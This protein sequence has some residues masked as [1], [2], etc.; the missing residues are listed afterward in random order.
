MGIGF[1]SGLVSKILVSALVVGAMTSVSFGTFA[2]FAAQ[3]SNGGS[4]FASGTLV[5]S[6][7]KQGGAAC[8]STTGG[9]TDTNA[10]NCS[11]VFDLGHKAAVR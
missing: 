10:N 9:A 11:K 5:L 2:S 8:L 7:T 3:T 1:G 6:N 4:G